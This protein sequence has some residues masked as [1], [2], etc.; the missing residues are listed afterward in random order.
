MVATGGGKTFIAAMVAQSVVAKGGRLFFIVDSLEL[1]DQAAMAFAKAG[2]G[3]GVIQGMHEWT[4]Y[5]QPV[6]VATIQTL[7][8]RWSRLAVHLMPT[9]L[10]VDECHV[11]HKAHEKIIRE[12]THKSIPVIGLS[13]TPFRRGLGKLFEELVV[14][15]TTADLTKEGYLAP[16][17]CYAPYIPNLD[18]VRKKN[19]GDWQEDALGEYMGAAKIVGDVVSAWKK[20]GEDRQTLV[21]ACN[22]AHSKLLRDAFKAEGIAADHIDGYETDKALRAQKVADFKAGKIKVL[23]NVAV[24]TKGFDA[25][26]TSCLVIARPTKS[27]MMHIQI[28]GRGLR[29]AP[30]KKDCIIIDH[31]GNCIRNGLPVETLPTEL[32]DGELKRNLDRKQKDSDGPTE[33]PCPSCGLLKLARRCPSC[34][35]M[36]EKKEDVDRVDGELREITSTKTV[37]RNASPEDKA[38]FYGQLKFY[39]HEHGYREGWAANQYRSKFGVWPNKYKDAPM[40]VPSQE[41]LNY[42][43]HKQ[44]AYAKRSA[45]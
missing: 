39:A 24:L 36:Y 15:A 3:V 30:G 11:I 26:Q 18:A 22:V 35:Y 17:K 41:T 34:G 16:A 45:A 1:V 4:D 28:L 9:V 37:N 31:A 13:A 32:D 38:Y 40:E 6:Q 27:L 2:L 19:D 42:I 25:P 7:R 12:C 21:F 8:S 23:C 10:M 29:T 44:I 20:L 14:G 5:S 33:H 43:K